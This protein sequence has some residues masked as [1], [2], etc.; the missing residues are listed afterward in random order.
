MLR[1]KP[2]W[3]GVKKKG[4]QRR[5]ALFCTGDYKR[6]SSVTQM[7]IDLEWEKLETNINCLAL[8]LTLP[9]MPPAH[10]DWH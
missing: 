2:I 10:T 3:S 6:E 1:A 8:L 4:I 5:A 9:L 7:L